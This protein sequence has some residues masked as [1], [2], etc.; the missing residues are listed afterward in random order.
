MKAR[1]KPPEKEK[2]AAKGA[3]ASGKNRLGEAYQS[4][5]PESTLKS[6]IGT[7]LLCLQFPVGQPLSQIGWQLFERLLRRYVDARVVPQSGPEPPES[8]NGSQRVDR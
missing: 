3:T 8:T 7:L 5:A 6:E 4:P 2:A 1:T